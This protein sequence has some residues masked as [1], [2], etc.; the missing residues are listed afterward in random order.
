ME[1]EIRHVMYRVLLEDEEEER[2]LKTGAKP[3]PNEPEP[4]KRPKH[5]PEPGDEEDEEKGMESE[6]SGHDTAAEEKNIF[7]HW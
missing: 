4:D 6:G 1:M 3:V 2:V 7:I 5:C